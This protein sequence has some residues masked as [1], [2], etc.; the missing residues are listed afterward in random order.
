[1][2]A[3]ERLALVTIAHGRHAHLAA[4]VEHLARGTRRPDRHVV[5]SMADEQIAPLLSGVPDTDVL[6][7]DADPAR[8]PLA[9]ARNAGATAALDGGADS[10]MFLDVDCL[11]GVRL[12]ERYAQVT[13]SAADSDGLT[14]VIW[15][16][17]VHYLPALE[18]GEA[19]YS[20]T[21]LALSRPHPARPV[22]DGDRL[23]DEPRLELFWS[24]S[25]ALTAATW[26]RL[27]GFCE[28][29]VGYGAEDTDLARVLGRESGRL[30]WVGGATAYHQHH[31]TSTPPVQ[32]V[33]PIVRNANV[34]HRRW[35]DYP[36]L[37][38]LREFESQGLVRHDE[39]TGEW[40]VC[41]DTRAVTTL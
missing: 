39:R 9:A 36:M 32:H 10:L 40:S 30:T 34:F 18:R 28:D 4:Q 7:V 11:P 27:G 31:P 14:P 38:W 33:A 24:L 16:G 5:V 37:G 12:L 15:S 26:Q 17:P 20:A 22:P 8:L 3:G 1:M 13:S 6:S 29:Y 21:D 2:S 23:L 41:Q 35:G 25:F 19:S